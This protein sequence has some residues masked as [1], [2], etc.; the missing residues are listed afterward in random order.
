MMATA[1]VEHVVKRCGDSAEDAALAAAA[2][3][4]DHK[5]FGVLVA[6]Y[7]NLVCSIAYAIT[8][9][10]SQSEEVAQET[11]IAAWRWLPR[12]KELER[13][14]SWLCGITRNLSK[15]SRYE[16]HTSLPGQAISLE[17][18]AHVASVEPSP[19]ERAV[20]REEEVLLWR[21]LGAIPESYRV[22]LVLFYRD[23]QSI[24]D[25]ADALDLSST[26]VRQKLWR[27]RQMLQEQML[28]L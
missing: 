5:A 7:Q 8:G 3:L 13:F 4:G 14:R 22:P 25:V 9:S 16:E 12:L 24:K 15:R 27:G 10:L 28:Q 18:G 2:R 20:T 19:L 23:Q 17:S 26:N 1:P 11:F 21:A 6:R